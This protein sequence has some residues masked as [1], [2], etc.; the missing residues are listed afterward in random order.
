MNSALNLRQCNAISVNCF[1]A[2]TNITSVYVRVSVSVCIKCYSTFRMKRVRCR[3][4]TKQKTAE[5]VFGIK[6]YRYQYTLT[7]IIWL[8]KK[9]TQNEYVYAYNKLDEIKDV[10]VNVRMGQDI[11]FAVLHEHLQTRHT[12][13]H[14]HCAFSCSTSR[15]CAIPFDF[16]WYHLFLL[17]SPKKENYPIQKTGCKTDFK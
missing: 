11:L 13:T 10:R 8:E 2:V 1:L 14:T 12:H 16:F 15:V 5:K 17:S 9:A 3:I 6:I 4:N 7:L